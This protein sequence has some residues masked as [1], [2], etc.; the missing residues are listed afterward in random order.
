MVMISEIFRRDTRDF[1]RLFVHLVLY[2]FLPN[3]F[4]AKGKQG[5]EYNYTILFLGAD[6]HR[7]PFF[8]EILVPL[9]KSLKKYYGG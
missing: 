4:W 7:R 6:A 9:N 1:L 2:F 8:T 5:I 3:P